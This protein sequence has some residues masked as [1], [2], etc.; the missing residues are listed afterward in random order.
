M[1]P[2]KCIYNRFL[3]VIIF[4]IFPLSSRYLSILLDES[5][6]LR[7]N[8][9]A[10]LARRALFGNPR[11][12]RS[13]CRYTL[14]PFPPSFRSFLLVPRTSLRPLSIL[15]ASFSFACLVYAHASFHILP[16]YAICSLRS[17]NAAR[18]PPRY[19]RESRVAFSPT[20]RAFCALPRQSIENY[21]L[22]RRRQI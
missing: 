18:V 14:Q 20:L 2:L 22:L 10:S 16:L 3:L 8:A 4:S 17:W 19:R 6:S 12:S 13:H 9:I 21:K 1:K 7:R 15:L 11:W 5:S